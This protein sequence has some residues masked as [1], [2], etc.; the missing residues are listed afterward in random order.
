LQPRGS[1]FAMKIFLTYASEDKATAE[2]IAFSLRDRGHTVFLD[3][4]DLPPGESFDQQIERGVNDSDIFIFLISP[5]S[6]AEGRYTLTELMFA[7]RKWRSPNNRVLPVMARKTPR[8]RVPTYLKAVTILEPEGN[9]AADTSA[10]ADKMRPRNLWRLAA[11]SLRYPWLPVAATLVALI[12]ASLI[13][14]VERPGKVPPIAI[15]E[16]VTITTSPSSNAGSGTASQQS[17]TAANVKFINDTNETVKLYW[18]D[19]DGGEIL[20][21]SLLPH[22]SI[23]QPTF[24]GHLWIAKTTEGVV[25]LK[26]V[27]KER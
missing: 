10:A 1:P 5:D 20:Y 4:D 23:T 6:V 25:L 17:D 24:T 19:F 26:Y 27:V 16:N 11:P 9:V 2:S 13:W 15:G 21:S 18:V 12:V 3:R 22:T 14:L 7:R 8:E